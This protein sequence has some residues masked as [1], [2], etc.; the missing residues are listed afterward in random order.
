MVQAQAACLSRKTRSTPFLPSMQITA[1]IASM[2]KETLA[3]HTARRP[4]YQCTAF[5]PLPSTAVTCPPVIVADPLAQ[6]VRGPLQTLSAHHH[7]DA[8]DARVGVYL[9]VAQRGLPAVLGARQEA[10][11]QGRARARMMS[12]VALALLGLAACKHSV[13]LES[14]E[15]TSRHRAGRVGSFR[16]SLVLLL[17]TGH[18]GG[19]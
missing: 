3:P 2:R 17:I 13:G 12:R 4:C 11:A 15:G 9:L 14:L 5:H 19:F 10:A 8:H 6:G 1:A 16:F 18:L 7:R